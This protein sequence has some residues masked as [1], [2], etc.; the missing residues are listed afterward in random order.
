MN[1]SGYIQFW[2]QTIASLFTNSLPQNFPMSLGVNIQNNFMPE[3]FMGDPNNCSFVIV[4]LNPGAGVCHSCFKQQNVSGTLINK[5]KTKG[6][7]NAVKDFPYLRDGKTVGLTD[8]NDSSG[9]EWWK[10]KE[11]WIKH[12]LNVCDPSYNPSNPIP[13]GYFPFAME[14][15]AWHTKNWPKAL[16]K[17]MESSGVHGSVVFSDVI[18]P[19]YEAIKKSKFKFA[20]CV[21]K[22]IGDITG[23]FAMFKK[24][25]SIQ[26]LPTKERYYDVYSDGKGCYIVNT[27][28][29]GGNTYPSDAF[30]KEEEKIFRNHQIIP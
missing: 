18:G 15:F 28:A 20:F 23:S 6:Y 11:K 29:Q 19:L 22:P 10:S 27:W 7:S 16:N 4:N 13:E 5:V 2:D 25:N 14:L 8:W 9:S 30:Y 12:M 17:K 26:P 24:L 21:G 1:L 3:P